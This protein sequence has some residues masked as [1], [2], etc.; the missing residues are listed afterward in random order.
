MSFVNTRTA[1]TGRAPWCLYRWPPGARCS[2]AQRAC[3]PG[4]SAGAASGA[5]LGPRAGSGRAVR[6]ALGQRRAAAPLPSPDRWSPSVRFVP[7]MG[8]PCCGCFVDAIWWTSLHVADSAPL[9]CSAC[10]TSR[11]PTVSADGLTADILFFIRSCMAVPVTG[12]TRRPGY[13]PVSCR[14]RGCLRLSTLWRSPAHLLLF[15]FIA[16]RLSL[17]PGATCRVLVTGV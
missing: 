7:T 15:F 8:I 13:R 2:P 3:A 1:R 5:C 14:A 17:R 11:C 9:Y 16:A 4:D 6:A 12:A 10:G